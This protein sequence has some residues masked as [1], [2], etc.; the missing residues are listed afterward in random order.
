MVLGKKEREAVRG[1]G[2]NPDRKEEDVD[3]NGQ[4]INTELDEEGVLAPISS[5]IQAPIPE[6]QPAPFPQ[7]ELQP[8]SQPDSQ[9]ESSQPEPQPE[10]QPAVSEPVA[11]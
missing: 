6:P 7:A 9:L 8:E 10:S 2:K 4:P 11:V 1:C 3:E 5:S